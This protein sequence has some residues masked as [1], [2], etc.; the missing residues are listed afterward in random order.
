MTTLQQVLDD[1]D[2][3]S[4]DT[5]R[6]I[7]EHDGRAT[8]SEIRDVT[9]L[10]NSQVAYRRD[11]LEAYGLISITTGDPTGERT[12][13]K[14][15]VLTESARS[16]IESGLF[17]LYNAPVTGDVKQLST[18][19]N[20]LRDRVDDLSE[21]MEHVERRVARLDSRLEK[22]NAHL[23]EQ[24]GE[25]EDLRAATEEE[26]MASVMG[27]LRSELEALRADVSELD[28]RKKDKLFK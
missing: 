26:T 10:S 8:T 13:P 6:A 24:L 15:H 18:Q 16:H 14:V 3:K 28:E 12:P 17:E 23:D 11:K 19:A 1:L 21:T 27:E 25:P 22:L 7:A 5:L 20:H 9:G 2:P 4:I